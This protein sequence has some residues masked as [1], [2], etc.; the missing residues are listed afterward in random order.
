MHRRCASPRCPITCARPPSPTEPRDD[1]LVGAEAFWWSADATI[2]TTTGQETRAVLVQAQ[3]AA[4]ATEDPKAGDQW[5]FG[6][7]RF[8]VDDAV[9][10][11]R[12]RFT[13]RYGVDILQ[14]D[15]RRVFG[16][17][18]IGC[19]ATPCDFT[20]ALPGTSRIT[21]FLQC[22][23][24]PPPAGYLGDPNVACTVTGSRNG[25]N[26]FRVE[27]ESSPGS[28]TWALVGET[29]LFTVSGKLTTPVA[30]P[31]PTNQPPNAVDDVASTS[32][33]T[34]TT[35]AV[36]GNDSDP[37]AGDVLNIV[38]VTNGANGT[39]TIT[40]STVTYTPNAG[41]S[42]ADAF[43]YTI[44]DPGGLTDSATV[45]VT[46]DP[47]GI[48]RAPVAGNDAF[49]FTLPRLGSILPAAVAT[50]PGVL[51]NDTDADGNPLTA[52][53][54]AGPAA[55]PLAPGFPQIVL[56]PEGSIHTSMVWVS[57]RPR[58]PSPS[59]TPRTTARRTAT[60]RR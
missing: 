33:N 44:G 9:P 11:A 14:A 5:A 31:P 57:R 27:R 2:T 16:T 43:Q 19:F 53:L 60:S 13:T 23:S 26:F 37:N 29:N 46:I 21:N 4:F 59:P 41:F 6:R 45:S 50:I 56:G 22:V 24:P 40:G 3:E 34:L 28:N 10:F 17:S 36:M 20:L 32:F 35:I 38:S 58:S 47:P 52:V 55:D 30:T 39:V 8:R 51:A 54:V 15:D 12:Y 48:N 49:S 18:D 7:L 25:T 1:Q 42:G